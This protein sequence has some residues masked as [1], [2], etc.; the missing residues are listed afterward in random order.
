MW[1]NC[2]VGVHFVL[3]CAVRQGGVLLFS[4]YVEHLI[5]LLKQS[6]YGT[7][8]GTSLLAPFCL[9][10]VTTSHIVY[11]CYCVLHLLGFMSVRRR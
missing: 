10:S 2:V 9:I 8:I 11:E 6:G 3:L 4:V 5:R 1:N 7:Y